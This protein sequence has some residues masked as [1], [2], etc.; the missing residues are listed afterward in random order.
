MCHFAWQIVAQWTTSIWSL[1]LL[2]E[3]IS[4]CVVKTILFEFIKM[5]EAFVTTGQ[6]V[7]DG[8]EKLE[9]HNKAAAF[10]LPLPVSNSS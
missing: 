1:A 3:D 4:S 5:R 10:A 6:L 9:I 8:G 7:S 2:L